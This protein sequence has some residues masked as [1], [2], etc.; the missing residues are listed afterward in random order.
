MVNQPSSLTE[1]RLHLYDIFII[2][3]IAR[4]LRNVSLTLEYPLMYFFECATGYRPMSSHF[5]CFDF[6]VRLPR[7]FFL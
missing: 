2:F 1:Y 4:T 7:N 6:F 5:K 3:Q